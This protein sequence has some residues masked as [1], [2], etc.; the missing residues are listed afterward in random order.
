MGIQKQ[1]DKMKGKL[2]E[3]QNRAKGQEDLIE[4]ETWL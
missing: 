1:I 2:Q 4:V 3:T